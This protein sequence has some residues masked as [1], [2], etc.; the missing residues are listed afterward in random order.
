MVLLG[1]AE[2]VEQLQQLTHMHVML[3]HA[4]VVFVT[5]RA[6]DFRVFFLHVRAEVHARGVPPA[7][8]TACRPHAGA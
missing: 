6:G 8:R 7:R 3:D 5:A 4:V 2:V 1:D